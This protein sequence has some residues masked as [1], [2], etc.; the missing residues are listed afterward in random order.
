MTG[1]EF[2]FFA[3]AALFAASA[4]LITTEAKAYRSSDGR[5]EFHGFL[6]DVTFVREDRGVSKNRNTLQLELDHKTA[7]SGVF[8]KFS[9]HIALRA[10][11]DGV[12]DIN[13][14]EFGKTA[15][16]P[17]Q[18]ENL[19]GPAFVAALPPGA[20]PPFLG[21]PTTAH[22]FGL[23][24][25]LAGPPPNLGINLA[26]N[27][28]DGLRVLGFPL[29]PQA[30]GLA[31]GVPVRPCNVDS[32]G[33]IPGYLNFSEDDLRFPTFNSR[34]DFLREAY[35]DATLPLSN[36]AELGFRLGRQQV[37]WGRTDLFRVLD[38]INPVEF[39][40]NNIYDELED[41]RIP[42]WILTTELR[43][44][45][46]GAFDDL[47]FQVVWNFDKFRPSSLGQGG[48]PNQIIGAGALLRGLKNCWDNGCTVAN[49]ADPLGLNQGLVATNIP[50]G[51]IGIRQA[52]MP[53]WSLDN[54]QIGGRIEGLLAGVG[55]SINYLHF[56]Q[57]LPSL[58][59]GIPA[60]NPFG[61]LTGPNCATF[62][63]CPFPADLGARPRPFLPAFDIH[64]PTVDLVGGSLDFYVDNIKSVFRVEAAYTS[65]EEFANGLR[66][67]GFSESDVIRYVIGIDRNTFIPFLNKHRSFLFSAQIFGQHL[68]DHELEPTV[69]STIGIPGFGKNGMPDWK[70]NW[71]GTLLIRGMYLNDRVN[72][73]ILIARD[74]RA[75][76]NVIG[77]SVDWLVNDNWR[78]IFGANIKFGTGAQKF[79]D[80]R[81]GNQF[82]P[83][84]ATPLH[85]SPFQQ[86]SVGLS[87]FEP[88]GRFRSGPI[89]MAQ[90][91][92]EFQLTVRYRF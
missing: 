51:V 12:Y 45:A 64:F 77:P 68:L 46:T 44:G 7:S 55:F 78:I 53:K 38:V 39:S 83:F 59:G 11:Y 17:I 79:D 52:V 71:I 4:M 14:D 61:P 62:P 89:G 81:T 67:D 29:H 24:L 35:L 66:P 33:C 30:G 54:T 20:A 49:F 65:G 27:P 6:E 10:T 21:R 9:I 90:K 60:L 48:T 85:A 26:T 50:A 57:Q 15:G 56:R 73:Q 2:G 76:A 63:A 25:P 58:R 84:T 69:G 91:E 1:R 42:M 23:P 34:V 36:G 47:N 16:G 43:L 18:L 22:G 87:G 41:I 92:D 40:R 13:P 75:H 32:R 70:N 5:T 37:V 86:G 8:S 88:L 3:A 28:N 80:G 19:G 31:F 72:P 82:P 74:F